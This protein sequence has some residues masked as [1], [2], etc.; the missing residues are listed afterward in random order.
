MAISSFPKRFTLLEEEDYFVEIIKFEASKHSFAQE[1]KA[2]L[3]K[4]EQ[5]LNTDEYF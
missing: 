2:L 3:G 5:V 1:W 4:A